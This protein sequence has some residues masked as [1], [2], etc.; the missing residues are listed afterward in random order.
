MI[1]RLNKII[2]SSVV[3]LALAGCELTIAW[4]DTTGNHRSSRDAEIDYA[5]CYQQANLPPIELGPVSAATYAAIDRL[6][7]CMADRGWKAKNSGS[8]YVPRSSGREISQ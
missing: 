8:I 6:K 5:S 7:T 3:L 4:E 1:A 2:Y